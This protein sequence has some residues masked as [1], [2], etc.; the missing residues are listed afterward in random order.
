VEVRAASV[1]PVD[2][3]VRAGVQG[4]EP[5]DLPATP[6]TDFAGVVVA[7]GDR[8]DGLAAGDHVVG[9]YMDRWTPYDGTFAEYVAAPTDR[10]APLPQDVTFEQAAAAA[11]VGTTAYGALV[12]YGGVRLG[13]TCLVHGGSGG[14][15]HVAV[16]MADRAGATVVATAGSEAA[17]NRVRELGAAH[18]FDYGRDPDDLARA[19]GDVGPVDVVLDHKIDRYLDLDVRVAA[20]GA[21]VVSIEASGAPVR[22]TTPPQA[23][24]KDLCLY[25]IGPSRRMDRVEAL[26]TVGRLLSRGDLR[27]EIARRYSLSE[28]AQAHRD[29]V[30][31]SFVGKL[32]VRP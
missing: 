5:P 25:Q 12:E 6:G 21:T 32:V 4:K 1:N 3:K 16:Q 17:R 30:E 18:V 26:R 9:D 23:R 15:G 19:V 7:A 8:V 13:D 14:V 31:E 28:A 11:H 24:Q 29:V 10:V 20:P 2:T 27:V 22:F